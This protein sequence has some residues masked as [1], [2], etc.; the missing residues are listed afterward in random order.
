MG[1]FIYSDVARLDLDDRVL[2]HVQAVFANK[3]RRAESF[4][5]TWTDETGADPARSSVW[6]HPAATMA[7]SYAETGPY[8]LS[9]SW[10]EALLHTANS[11]AGLHLV[12][13]TT[14]PA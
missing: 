7:F 5:F 10:V 11:A 3:L 1:T 9:R 14:D 12:P 2:A 6:I 4:M 13:E 8:S